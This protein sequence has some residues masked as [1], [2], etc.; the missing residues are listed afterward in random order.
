MKEVIVK[1]EV[2][3]RV[4]AFLDRYPFLNTVVISLF[5]LFF[6][7]LVRFIFNSNID[8]KK[9]ESAEKALY[10]KKVGQ[11][12]FY[13]LLVSFLL[14][15]VSQLQVFFVSL[16][17]VAAAIVI[18]L[19]ELIMCI[20]GGTLIK[21]GK[22]F[23]TGDRIDISDTRGF[24]IEKSLL[25]T[26]I[27]EIGPEK[28]SQQTTGDII[29]IPNSLM[30]SHTLKNESYFRGYSI[31]SFLFRVLKIENFDFYEEGLLKHAREISEKY[32]E[33]A[34]VEISNFCQR[35]G[36][37][38]PVISPRTKIITDEKGGISLLVKLPVKNSQVGE[39]EQELNRCYLNLRM[40]K[41]KESKEARDN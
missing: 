21:I 24:V 15:W 6:Y 8:R 35:E 16:M 4:S 32:E 20:T 25:T 38:I 28:N 19:K 23:K 29:T 9:L 13:I 31:K 27:L 5:L 30:L 10:K 22:V 33:E 11:Y 40:L 2:L 3:E 18:A 39:I 37:S 7:Y 26:K 12:L 14:L 34:R 17:A 1:I 41:S 36:I